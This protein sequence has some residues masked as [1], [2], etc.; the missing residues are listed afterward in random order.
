[1]TT[2]NI[3]T[4]TI[5]TSVGK[6]MSLLFNMLSRFLIGFLQRSK[7]L[8]IS[9]LLSQS[10]VI[11]EPKKM[12][13][14]TAFIASSSIY[15]EVMG[16]NGMFFIFC[17][18]SSK[19][20]FS[21]SSFTY[22]KRFFSSSLL[23]AI[24]VVSSAYLRL[25]IFL[26]AIFIPASTSPPFCVLYSAYTLTKQGDNTQPW[27]TPFP[28]WN[29]SIVPC[30]VLT[31]VSWPAYRFLK[32]QVRCSGIPFLPGASTG[33]PTHDKVM[34]R[35]PEKQGF[36]TQE[37]P[38]TCSSIYP[39]TRICLSYYFMCFTNS[40]DINGAIP[41]HLSLERVNLGL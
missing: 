40:S 26:P 7:H 30:S 32:R 22:I 38:L 24:R 5:W 18:L 3:I 4:L 29:Q 2:G 35:R 25:L 31:V 20:G 21:L 14:V 9:W 15:H 27:H 37:T 16:P 17:M 1:M 41:D 11:L 34:R 12:K 8:L 28:V 10:A 19:P 36:R 23:S 6:V 13:S 33:D 39:K